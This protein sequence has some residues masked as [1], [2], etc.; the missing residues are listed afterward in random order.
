MKCCVLFESYYQFI[1]KK[2]WSYTLD[3]ISAYDISA[4]IQYVLGIT[5][6]GI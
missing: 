2:Y 6:S 5:Q 3:Q 1:D 4:N